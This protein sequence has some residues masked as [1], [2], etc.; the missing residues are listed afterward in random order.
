MWVLGPIGFGMPW[1]LLGLL[2]LPALWLL[3]RAVPPA[4]IRR[5]FPG[6]ALL[7]GLRDDRPETDRTPW[8]LLLLRM[9]ALAAVI[10]AFAGPVLNPRQDEAGR[11]PLLILTDGSWASARDWSR[12]TDRIVALLQEAGR[13]GRPVAVVS[14]T[15]L[16]AQARDG[17]GGPQ[18]ME[19]R[20]WESR[21]PNIQPKPWA[22]DARAVARWAAGLSGRFQTYW[23]SDGLARDSH[24]A[25][26]EALERHGPV[27]VIESRRP[28]Y[29]LRPPIFRDGAIEVTALR[30]AAGPRARIDVMARGPGPSGVERVLAQT[31]LTFAPGASEATARLQMQPELRNRVTRF[32]IDGSRTAGA[33]SLTDDALKR[34]KVALLGPPDRERLQLLSPLF[35]LREA[36][37]P[38]TDLIDGSFDDI[39]L[40]APDV[41]I[42]A[43]IAKLSPNEETALLAW[44]R[45]GGLL[46][47]FAGPRLAASDLSRETEDPLMPVRLRLGGRTVGGAMS[48]GQPKK[49]AP[50]PKDSPFYGLAIPGDVT[51]KAQVLAQ[52]DPTLSKR[53][54]A[55]LA[56][57]TPLVTRKAVGKGQVV[58]FHVTANAEW[59]TLPL[60]G[61]FVQML[62]RLAVSTRPERP[63]A[64][65]MKGTTWVPVRL[66]D[67]FGATSDAGQMAGLAGERLIAARAGPET[68]PGLYRSG[69]RRLALNVTDAKTVLKP[70]AWPPG[71]VVE[72]LNATHETPLAWILLCAA[73]ILFLFD[74]LASMALSGHLRRSARAGVRGGATAAL[75]LIALAAYPGPGR[76][77]NI[78]KPGDAF[79]IQAT[80]GMVLAH[81]LTGNARVDAIA[82]AGLQGLSDVLTERTSVE[83]KTPMGVNIETD[84]LSF[85]PFLYWPITADEPIPS[86]GAYAKL[87]EYLRTGG[88]IVFDTRDAD[89]A[90]GGVVTPNQRRLRQIALGLDIPPL[91]PVPKDHVLTRT[92]YLIQ[93]FPGRYDSGIT[94]VEAAPPDAKKVEGM[95]FRNLNDG[96]TPVVIGSNDWAAAWAVN[97]HG[98]PMFPVGSGYAGERQREIAYRFGVNLIMYVLTGNYK[99]DQVHVPALLERLGQ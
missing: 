57:G 36:L 47:R 7:L 82:Q 70:A 26:L 51:V 79:A 55:S 32:Q 59:S 41:I 10:V 85:F 8:W 4:P 81:V 56:D 74:I 87:N 46:V 37:A 15:D 75:V 94:W 40:A 39:L 65:Q 29:A 17:A 86:A 22:P 30:A 63:D 35:Y 93:D 19:A 2:A 13:A 33:I 9:L 52:P 61:L 80:A 58:L 78:T 12:R 97:A 84:D 27:R 89:L 98:L 83:P 48:W 16:P 25:L 60:S 18:F 53:T 64:T 50:F 6:V 44:T 76:A 72:G 42:L 38:T 14:L 91:S 1:L 20:A 34:R 54:I 66:L 3:L 68:P 95:P 49:L 45:K 62:N 31:A 43:D 71:V 88:M 69:D 77:Q 73:L 96:V 67:A 24:P 90:V 5:R 21:L 28:V 92:F 11:G 23:L 99:S